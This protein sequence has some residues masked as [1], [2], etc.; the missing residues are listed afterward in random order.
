MHLH[1]GPVQLSA[2]L[3]LPASTIGAV[4]RR[5]PVPHLIALDRIS[6]ELFRSR[7]TAER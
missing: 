2:E 7:P 4:L 6:G 1:A 3:E 5:W